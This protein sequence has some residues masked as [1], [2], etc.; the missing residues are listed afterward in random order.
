MGVVDCTVA[1]DQPELVAGEA[2]E[3]VAAAQPR[4]NPFRHLGDDG[5]RDI[6]A[7]RIIDPRQMIDADQHERAGGAEARALLDGLGERGDQMGAVELVGQRI[8]PRQLH[9]LLVAGMPFIVDANDALHARRLAVGA[10]KPA[11]GLLDPD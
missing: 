9:E 10:G 6:E 1:Q 11:A 8:V 5:V 4:T 3:H 2:A 7:E